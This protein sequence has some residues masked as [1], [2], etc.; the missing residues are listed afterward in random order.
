MYPCHCP[1]TGDR[2]TSPWQR[3]RHANVSVTPVWARVTELS[4]AESR[5]RSH[6]A[7]HRDSGITCDRGHLSQTPTGQPPAAE[8]VCVHMC[9]LYVCARACVCAC[10]RACVCMRPCVCHSHTGHS[11]CSILENLPSSGKIMTLKSLFMKLKNMQT[12]NTLII[13]RALICQHCGFTD[14]GASQM[15]PYS[16]F[17]FLM[18]D[19]G[20]RA[21]VKSSVYRK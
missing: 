21:L 1:H 13:L 20:Q 4:P 16:F 12:D 19:P 6:L 10:V 18:K 15:A 7:Y 3:V 5:A 11:T 14:L 2:V 8:T 9:V 17:L